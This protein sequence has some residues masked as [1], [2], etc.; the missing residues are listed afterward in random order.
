MELE[1]RSLQGQSRNKYQTR[2]NSYM[3][4]LSKLEKDLVSAVASLLVVMPSLTSDS[5]SKDYITLL[6]V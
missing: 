3:S 4:E 6:N 1:V 2:L 5:D